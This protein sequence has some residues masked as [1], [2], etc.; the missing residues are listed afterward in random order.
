M[1]CGRHTAKEFGTL[2][3][4][5]MIGV[6]NH[7]FGLLRGGEECV[8]NLPAADLACGVIGLGDCSG[9]GTDRFACFRLR[10]SPVRH[11][12]A[13]LI[14]ACHSGRERRLHDARRVEDCDFCVFGVVAV[15]LARAS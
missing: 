13:P 14:D 7:G 8:P 9:A 5:C 3:P 11:G 15:H 4:G 2:L 6:G 10:A 12:V 1:A